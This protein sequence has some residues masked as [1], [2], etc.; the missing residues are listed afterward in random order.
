MTK[1]YKF[2]FSETNYVEFTQKDFDGFKNVDFIDDNTKGK[3]IPVTRAFDKQKFY[4][5][6]P[7]DMIELLENG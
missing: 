2:R 6:A 1:K 3:V 7:L 5:I 4:V